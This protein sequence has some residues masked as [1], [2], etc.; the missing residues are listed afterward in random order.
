MSLGARGR[1]SF[2]PIIEHPDG[3]VEIGGAAKISTT[4]GNLQLLPA[5][6]GIVKIGDAGS[7]SHTLNTNDD[8]FVSG[9]LEVD[10]NAY[11]DNTAL[12]YAGNQTMDNIEV[13]FGDAPD[14]AID[15]SLLQTTEHTLIWG[16]GDTSKSIIF[17]D[18]A[19]R[20]KNFDHAAQN[21]PTIFVHSRTDPDTA[22]TQWIS[23]SHDV[24]DG[25][26]A[27]GLGTLNLGGTTVNFVNATRTTVGDAVMNAYVVL[28]IG[29]TEY[30]F[31]L[32]N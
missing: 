29:G 20:N 17:C 21:D 14:S 32:T 22:N 16:L 18:Y 27:C 19:D 30:K 25:V 23:M 28:E 5:A 26:I 9:K 6:G 2:G 11:F 13:R 7:T 15:W 24:T 10:G 1:Y 4:S 12:F 8:L 3:E 31:M